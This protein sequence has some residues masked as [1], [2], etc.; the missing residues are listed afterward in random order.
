[1]SQRMLARAY[2]PKKRVQ[3]EHLETIE[4]AEMSALTE[5]RGIRAVA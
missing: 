2:L 1:M 3:A 4:F 5:E